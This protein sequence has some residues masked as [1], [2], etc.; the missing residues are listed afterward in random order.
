MHRDRFYFWLLLLFFHFPALRL[1]AQDPHNFGPDQNGVEEMLHFILNAGKRELV[2]LTRELQ[3]E[4]A[5]YAAVFIPSYDKAVWRF[6][7]K[8][9]RYSDIIVHPLLRKQTGYM[10]WS[11]TTEELRAYEGDARFFPGGYKEVA[12]HLQPGL[13]FY[14]FKFVEPGHKLGSAYDALVY[15][16]GH[17]R[18]FHR[19]WAAKVE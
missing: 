10:L 1:Q 4:K 18:I 15:V 2:E 12:A 14:R 17:W 11:A 3:P 8:L 7:R 16:N 9:R 5:D 19:P 6:H 13:T